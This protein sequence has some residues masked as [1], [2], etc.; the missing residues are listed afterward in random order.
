MLWAALGIVRPPVPDALVFGS[1]GADSTVRIWRFVQDGDTLD[2][3]ETRGGAQV[4][5]AEW[6]REGKGL[7][8]SRT[9]FDAQRLPARARL[10]FSGGRARF[11]LTG[12]SGDTAAGLGPAIW[13]G[14]R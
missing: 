11:E 5:E 13:R 6:R 9:E 14:P 1:H 8:R 12:V 3:R 4:L 2:Y 10:G 7:G